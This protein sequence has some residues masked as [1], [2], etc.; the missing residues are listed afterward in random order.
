MKRAHVILAILA[1]LPAKASAQSL[2][3]THGL[4]VPV[5]G[6]D[7]RA[8]ALGVNG[9]GLL[10]LSTALL[11]P[12]EVGGVLRRGITATF[13][14]WAASVELNGEE[15]EIGGTRFPLIAVL[16]PVRRFTFTL[17][18]SGLL[19]QSWAIF[20]EGRQQLGGDSVETLDLIRSV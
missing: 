3:A 9:V 12:A 11:N 20:A 7:G 18:Y 17:G 6:V 5:E 13:Q 10:G 2:F 4:G 19:D 16:Y 8:R 14:P 1:L 15:G